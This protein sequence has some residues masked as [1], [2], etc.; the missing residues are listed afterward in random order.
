MWGSAPPVSAPSKGSFL[1]AKRG[2]ALGCDLTVH[3]DDVV[4]PEGWNQALL[5]IGEEQFSGHGSLDHH[6]GSLLWR[7]AATKV[8]VSHDPSG[9]VPITLTPL[10]AALLAAP[11]LC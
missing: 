9:T 8:I 7:K 6:R 4:A 5:N 3:H 1:A 10:G 11:G 2:V